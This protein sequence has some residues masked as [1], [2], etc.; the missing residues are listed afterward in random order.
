MIR[1]LTIL[2]CVVGLNAQNINY[3]KH[4]IHTHT[5]KS[6][7]IQVLGSYLKMND[8]LDVLNIK[9]SEF[10]TSTVNYDSLGDMD[11]YELELRYSISDSLMLDYTRTN[12]NISYGENVLNNNRDEIFLRY[13]FLNSKM[14]LING[15]SIDIGYVKNRAKD[16][17]IRDLDDINSMLN[18]VAKDEGVDYNI[19]I[20]PH[21]LAG[22]PFPHVLNDYT[23]DPVSPTVL[24]NGLELV[25]YFS[26]E[27]LSDE[28]QY[29]RLLA[30]ITSSHLLTD[31]FIGYKK[32]KISTFVDSSLHYETDISLQNELD[33]RNITPYKSLNRDEKM[34]FVGVNISYDD[35]KNNMAYE[36]YYEFDKI[37]RDNGLDY[38]D[39]NH[40]VKANISKVI[41][42]NLLLSVGGKIM[43]TQFS[44]QIPYLYNKYS[45]T[46]FDHKYGYMNIGLSYKFNIG[47]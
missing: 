12:E 13:N 36:L 6:G 24:G 18:K 4:N 38:R 34:A 41:D 8:T 22:S 35:A 39:Y 40:I 14:S 32:T 31:F 25:P 20:E 44:G 3:A 10:G 21:P 28:S 45:Q 43:M 11:G 2:F 42:E 17:Y 9:E 46:S 27:D 5:P 29:I 47:E 33:N 15:L 7:N 26:S 37:F 23:N 16:I 30:N 1:L 19:K